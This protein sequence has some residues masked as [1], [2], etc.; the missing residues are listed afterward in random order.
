MAL[1][2]PTPTQQLTRSLLVLARARAPAGWR[3]PLLALGLA[4]SLALAGHVNQDALP[5]PAPAATLAGAAAPDD[6][7]GRQALD[8]AR[9][10]LQL[11]EARG[12]ELERQID[13]LNQRLRESQEELTFFRKSRD[14]KR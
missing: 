5:W 8:E 12:K 4:A 9:L 11:S 7:P 1:R 2:R 6:R 3:V 14:A 13:T 10:A